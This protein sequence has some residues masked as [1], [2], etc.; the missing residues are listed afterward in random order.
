MNWGTNQNNGNLLG[1]TY[2]NGGPG[3]PQ[4]LTFSDK[5]SYDVLNRLTGVTDTG[6]SRTFGYDAYGNSWVTANSGVALARNT[7]TSNVYNGNNRIIG[8]SYDGAGNQTVV[9]GNALTYDAENR[10]TSATEPASL[11]GATEQYFYDGDGRRVE[12]SGPGGT[13]IYVYD[14]LG[15]LAAEYSRSLLGKL[16]KTCERFLSHDRKGGVGD[17]LRPAPGKAFARIRGKT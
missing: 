8:A 6:Y 17:E 5:Y 10:Q 1:A 11:G 12:K 7:P 15:K 16:L 14:A 3:Y 4:F 13:T 9:N 2:N